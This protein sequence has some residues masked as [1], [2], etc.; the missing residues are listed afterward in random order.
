MEDLFALAEEAVPGLHLPE[1]AG[2]RVA[3]GQVPERESA[4]AQARSAGKQ[5]GALGYAW[6]ALATDQV[7]VADETV[8]AEAL[9]APVAEEPHLLVYRLLP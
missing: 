1:L 6:L 5:L 9:G 3:L 8:L 2:R 4:V 7:P